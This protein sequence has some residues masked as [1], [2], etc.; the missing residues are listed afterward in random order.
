MLTRGRVLFYLFLAL[1]CYTLALT[2]TAS[3]S[4]ILFIVVGFVAEIL[5]W[6]NIFSRN[7]VESKSP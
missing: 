4:V 3:Y 6:F 2:F 7:D 1:I 5:F